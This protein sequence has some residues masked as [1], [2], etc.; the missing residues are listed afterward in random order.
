LIRSLRGL[1]PKF[2]S[3]NDAAIAAAAKAH[4]LHRRQSFFEVAEYPFY[5]AH[6]V[7]ETPADQAKTDGSEQTSNASDPVVNQ[8]V[9]NGATH[10]GPESTEKQ[11][12][13]AES[14]FFERL[15]PRAAITGRIPIT[16]CGDTVG[17]WPTDIQQSLE[18]RENVDPTVL[19][20]G[21]SYLRPFDTFI[22]MSQ[23]EPNPL[24]RPTLSA[25]KRS[26]TYY[27][28]VEHWS[29]GRRWIK[30][31]VRSLPA[32]F[33]RSRMVTGLTPT[34]QPTGVRHRKQLTQKTNMTLT[35]EQE[36]Q[37]WKDLFLIHYKKIFS[38]QPQEAADMAFDWTDEALKSVRFALKAQEEAKIEERKE[39]KR[40]RL[41]AQENEPDI[42][43]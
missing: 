34:N 35:T 15:K 39:R 17:Y 12:S 13:E 40:E 10:K 37:L 20:K 7:E 33:V 11:I 8:P 27:A 23:F 29:T 14:I 43:F 9:C 22:T 5:T 21:R 4:L 31:T 28:I 19:F 42:T 24:L 36:Q 18:R 26:V 38:G 32:P 2:G 6:A 41:K 3:F 25:D 1:T 30:E 16:I